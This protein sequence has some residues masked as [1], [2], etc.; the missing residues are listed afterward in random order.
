MPLTYATQLA[1]SANAPVGVALGEHLGRFDHVAG[2]NILGEC[3]P[4]AA[5]RLELSDELDARG[6]PK[7]RVHFSAGRNEQRLTAH[8][9]RTMRAIWSAAGAKDVWAFPRFAHVIGTCRMGASREHAV[10][11]ADGR[12]FDVPGLHIC[13]NSVFPSALSVNP[14]LLIMAL[15]LRTADR[16]IARHRSRND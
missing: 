11:D 3:L 15:S 16:F 5:N 12:A 8:G 7:P 9:E 4:S 2:I 10:V 1:R 6:L 13:D 14:A